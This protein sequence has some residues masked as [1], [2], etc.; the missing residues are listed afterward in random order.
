MSAA[1]MQQQQQAAQ[2]SSLHV[3]KL[4]ADTLLAFKIV[5][6][7][8]ITESTF[9]GQTGADWNAIYAQYSV[10]HAV[11][12][13]ANHWGHSQASL[14]AITTQIELPVYVCDDER[15]QHGSVSGDAEAALLRRAVDKHGRTL[16][17]GPL[18]EAIRERTGGILVTGDADDLECVMPHQ[19][20]TSE[21]FTFQVL[22]SFMCEKPRPWAAAAVHGLPMA[23]QL[24]AEQKHDAGQLGTLGSPD[25]S[26]YCSNG[27]VVH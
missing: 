4:P 8:V 24:S 18:M 7:T 10:Q 21:K 3:H 26:E 14:V 17:V 9:A 11:R 25:L 20:V 6:G 27:P 16:G 22:C 13:L 1:K 2:P 12:Y 19:L 23:V 5:P 15:L